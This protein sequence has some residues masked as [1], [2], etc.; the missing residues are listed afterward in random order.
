MTAQQEEPEEAE[1][2]EEDENPAATFMLKEGEPVQPKP[3]F[4]TKHMD[5]GLYTTPAGLLAASVLTMTGTIGQ[6]AALLYAVQQ[7]DFGDGEAFMVIGIVAALLNLWYARRS[8]EQNLPNGATLPPP[9]P[10]AE[11]KPPVMIVIKA[12]DAV[13]AAV[14]GGGVGPPAGVTDRVQAVEQA[15]V[16]A[17]EARTS[18]EDAIAATDE[19]IGVGQA[20]VLAEQARDAAEQAVAAA[21]Q[22]CDADEVFAFVIPTMSA[23]SAPA[24]EPPRPSA[25]P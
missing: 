3:K 8:T 2:A 14:V 4:Q 25:I 23:P 24:P 22:A 10:P 7:T 9:T 16:A 5:A 1:E 20:R 21:E 15:L 12:S 17:V 13:R 11:E 6:S 18:A 19:A